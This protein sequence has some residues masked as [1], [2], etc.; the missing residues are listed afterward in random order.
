MGKEFFKYV[1]G[2]VFSPRC[3]QLV[4][5]VKDKP[6][7]QRGKFNAPGGKDRIQRNSCRCNATRD[8]RRNES[9]GQFQRRTQLRDSSD[10]TKYHSFLLLY[11]WSS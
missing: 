4:M 2:L 8:A 1:V 3:D 10:A 7:W 6:D 5:L 11:L 9:H